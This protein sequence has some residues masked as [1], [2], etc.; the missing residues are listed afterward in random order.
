MN[1]RDRIAGEIRA[2]HRRIP[3]QVA[4]LSRVALVE[5]IPDGEWKAMHAGTCSLCGSS[6]GRL[7]AG[8]WFC[9]VC[10]PHR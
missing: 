4:E 10:V 1:T 6:E 2:R 7:Y 5:S 8:G 3:D 9:D